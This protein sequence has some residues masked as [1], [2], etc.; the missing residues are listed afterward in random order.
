[1][2]TGIAYSIFENFSNF[3]EMKHLLELNIEQEFII[4]ERMHLN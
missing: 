4:D 3:D 1:M 2:Y